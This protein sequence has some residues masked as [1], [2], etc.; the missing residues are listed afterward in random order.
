MVVSRSSARRDFS[1]MVPMKMK[2]GTANS[3]KFDMMPKRRGG[4]AC[5]SDQLS[6]PA[7]T[8]MPAN[9]SAVPPKANA[10]GYPVKMSRRAPANMRGASRSADIR[11][12]VSS[13]AETVQEKRPGH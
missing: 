4:I 10:T 13:F 8:P 2:N 11:R 6:S 9:R 1:S 5:R 7:S 12:S 3:T